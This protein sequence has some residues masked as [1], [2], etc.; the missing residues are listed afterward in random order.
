MTAATARR[1]AFKQSDVTR[2]VKGVAK[3]GMRVGRVE[4]TPTGNIVIQSEGAPNQAGTRNP[5][6]DVLS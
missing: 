4:I 6:D 5:W 3:A 1:T 2:A